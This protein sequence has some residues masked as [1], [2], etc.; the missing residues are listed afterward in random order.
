[1]PQT[2]L[3]KNLPGQALW[4]DTVLDESLLPGGHTQFPGPARTGSRESGLRKDERDRG[5]D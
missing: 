5:D 1:M 4:E 3:P 2:R